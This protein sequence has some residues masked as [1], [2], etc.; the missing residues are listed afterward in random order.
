[1]ISEKRLYLT[2]LACHSSHA[3]GGGFW[4]YLTDLAPGIWVLSHG[5]GMPFA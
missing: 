2:D 3:F 1:M 5:F 4:G